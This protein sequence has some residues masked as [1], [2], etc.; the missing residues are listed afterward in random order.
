M[1]DAEIKRLV[2]DTESRFGVKNRVAEAP[3]A[4]G[5]GCCSGKGDKVKISADL[6]KL[7]KQ[8]LREIVESELK[9]CDGCCN[10]KGKQNSS[11]VRSELLLEDDIISLHRSGQTVLNIGKNCIITPLAADRARELGMEIINEESSV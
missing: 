6:F 7:L 3:K 10:T 11:E 8:L 5:Q 4:L 2:E 1:T 9:I